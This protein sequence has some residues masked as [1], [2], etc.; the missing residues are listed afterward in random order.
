MASLGP[1]RRNVHLNSIEDGERGLRYGAMQLSP[2]RWTDPAQ[3]NMHCDTFC[4]YSWSYLQI[5]VIYQFRVGE[6]PSIPMSFSSIL[7]HPSKCSTS[8]FRASSALRLSKRSRHH[9]PLN[10]RTTGILQHPPRAS[11]FPHES[12]QALR[13]LRA[14]FSA[15]RVSRSA[16]STSIVARLASSSRSS[17][18]D[19]RSISAIIALFF[20]SAMTS[21]Q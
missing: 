8:Q 19:S 1:L 9:A 2:M 4:S 21:R 16:C 5:H 20:L 3:I 11:R 7:S 18:A 14:S 12:Q 6:S 13:A 15:W 17:L 10:H